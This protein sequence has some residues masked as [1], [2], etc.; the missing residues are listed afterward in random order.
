ML[1]NVCGKEDMLICAPVTMLTP[2]ELWV[3][4]ESAKSQLCVL[5]R[6]FMYLLII[7]PGLN[8]DGV[9]NKI[10]SG[11]PYPLGLNI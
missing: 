5:S 8:I 9:M 11:S 3:C 10:T 4:Q 6:L 7:R 2:A 1:P